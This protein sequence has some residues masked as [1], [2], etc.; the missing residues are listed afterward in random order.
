M[1][2]EWRGGRIDE[3]CASVRIN[4]KSTPPLR[5]FSGCCCENG[6]PG[7]APLARI[8]LDDYKTFHDGQMINRDY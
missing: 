3:M 2:G 4:L 5:C 8:G 1:D 6:A 7:I